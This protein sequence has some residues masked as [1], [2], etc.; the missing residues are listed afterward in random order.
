MVPVLTM[1]TLAITSGQWEQIYTVKNL[2]AA[3]IYLKHVSGAL[4]HKDK[5]NIWSELGTCGTSFELIFSEM[6]YSFCSWRLLCVVN[7]FA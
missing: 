2:F 1:A 7:Q 5:I 3:C 6:E 4:F